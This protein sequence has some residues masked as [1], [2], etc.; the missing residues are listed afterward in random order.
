MRGPLVS[1]HR[2]AGAG[3][4]PRVGGTCL[5]GTGARGARSG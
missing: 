2:N 1:G 5:A 4:A 3:A